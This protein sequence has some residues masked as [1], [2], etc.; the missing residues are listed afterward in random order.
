MAAGLARETLD[1]RAIQQSADHRDDE[2]EPESQPGKM[3]TVDVPLLAELLV[4]GCQPREAKDQLA[5]QHRAQ[6]R[7]R[8]DQQSHHDQPQPRVR[9]PCRHGP[10]PRHGRPAPGLPLRFRPGSRPNRW[11]LGPPHPIATGSNS[12]AGRDA[13]PR[14][15]AERS[16]CGYGRRGF[17]VRTGGVQ[18]DFG[19]AA[20]RSRVGVH[21][22]GRVTR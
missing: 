15:P 19:K 6:T 1:Q 14:P 12:P 10:D 17:R 16:V 8:P 5:E 11:P 22:R 2:Q 18:R 7:A 21:G 9:Q 13:H 3:T 20:A 4:A